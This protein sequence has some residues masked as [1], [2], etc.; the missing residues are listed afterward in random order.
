MPQAFNRFDPMSKSMYL[1]ALMPAMTDEVL[2]TPTTSFPPLGTDTIN[3]N[4]PKI[5]PQPQK[6]GF[7][8]NDGVDDGKIS[9]KEKL[10]AF[11]KGG[12]YNMVRGM[13]C[14][15]DGFSISR[16][17]LTAGAAAAIALTGPIGAA[18]AGG[19]GLIAA[20]A[21]FVKSANLAKTATTDQQAREAYEGFGEGTTTAAL[22]AFGGF[23]GLKSLKNN[24]SSG[25]EGSFIQKLTK[26]K[27]QTNTQTPPK[28]NPTSAE[29]QTGSTSTDGTTKPQLLL[30]DEA[31]INARH[32]KDGQIQ[33]P[34]KTNKPNTKYD[35]GPIEDY[36]PHDNN[37]KFLEG[38]FNKKPQLLL[39]DEATINA[40]HT[41]DGQIQ[42]PVKS[43]APNTAETAGNTNKA[44]IFGRI[45]NFGSYIADKAKGA[46][47]H[48]KQ[49]GNYVFGKI[50]NAKNWVINKLFGKP[51]PQNEDV[52]E[53]KL[54]ESK[55]NY[56]PI[57]QYLPHEEPHYN[58]PE[59][60][61]TK[62]PQLLL[63]DEATMTARH[64]AEGH[65][66][67][68]T[69]NTSATTADTGSTTSNHGILG[70]IK[71]A[72]SSVINWVKNKFF[73]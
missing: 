41:Q 16:T 70:H 44:G 13:F 40:R 6:D 56:E 59:G 7:Y 57:E 58:I 34:A 15:K 14:D 66:T 54:L 49:F 33:L 69:E 9:F 38:T 63:E 5:K 1:E 45:K 31:T 30:E 28:D 12:T 50:K 42:L 53:L 39:E 62:K 36:L 52:V 32:I 27:P 8:K 71:D 37:P 4:G 48:V 26:W 11:V 24:F 17:L 35:L 10:K 43:S 68:G 2:S 3:P 67:A 19:I 73:G 65:G 47:N 23:K 29:N 46:F 72:G 21:N 60:T 61:F 18:V 22:S 25:T 55:P 51:Q 20:G 64:I